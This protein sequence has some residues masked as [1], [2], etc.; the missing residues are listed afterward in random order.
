MQIPPEWAEEPAPLLAMLSRR[1]SGGGEVAASPGDDR[2]LSSSEP[3]L[4]LQGFTMSLADHFL[5]RSLGRGGGPVAHGV[6]VA[7]DTARPMPNPAMFKLGSSRTDGNPIHNMYEMGKQVAT[8]GPEMVWRIHEGHRKTDGKEVSIFVFEKKC[9]EKLHKPKRRETVTELL[10]ASV[11]Q[12]ERY[13]HPRI[14]Q[15]MHPVE[16]CPE[17]LAFASE[18]VLACLANVLSP[19]SEGDR[20][21]GHGFAKDYSFLDIELKY[22][23]LQITEALSF[24]HY[25]AHILHSNVCP[26]SIFVTKRGT[27]KLGGLEFSEKIGEQDGTESI[28]C[29]AW[30]S[31]IP[32]M[33]QPDLDFIA[34]EIQTT[35]QCTLLSDLFSLGMVIC[36]VFNNGKSLIEANHSNTTYMKQFEVLSDQLKNTLMKI[37]VALQEAVVR[38]LNRD[39]RQ[40]PTAQ[41]LSL[42]K[43]FS[44]PAVHAL[45]FLDVI[46]MKDPSQKT[47]FF[48]NT[49]PE[50]L[51][52]IPRKLWFQHV[53][54]CLR[55]EMLAQEVLAAVLQ[56][57]LYIISEISQEEYET[58]ILPRFRCIFCWPKSI[59]ASVTL[60]ENLHIILEKTPKDEIQSDVMPI[61]YSALESNTAQIQR[62]CLL[63]VPNVAEYIDE[64]A[65]RKLVFP[66]ARA[67]YEKNSIDLLVTLYML[68]ALERILD[69]LERRI[70]LDELLPLLWDVRLQDPDII[71]AAVNVYR[72][73]LTDNKKYGLS[74]NLMATRVMP[75]LLPLTMN[76]ALHLDQFT[77]LVEVLQEMLDTIDKNQRNKL[78]LDDLVLNSPDHRRLPALR[79]HIS[80]DNMAAVTSGA[81]TFHIPNLRVECRRKTNSA[82]DF[83]RKS[84]G[85]AGSSGP[86]SPDSNLLRVHSAMIGRRLSDNELLNPPK[87]R[88]GSYSCGS[89]T[90]DLRVGQ[91]PIRRHSSTCPSE[92]RA[93]VF[94][95]SPPM[96]QLERSAACRSRPSRN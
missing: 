17:T 30:S 72:V 53:W 47:N 31:R 64:E 39:P 21:N 85:S 74:V 20:S 70:I 51:P 96:V 55:E 6:A 88:V 4:S 48:R 36:A 71:Q 38:L 15:V 29:Q 79:H 42:I 54:P 93:S 68:L 18:P 80:S 12:L 41:L 14:L 81:P 13:R 50:V 87:I 9:A 44:D 28:H 19:A 16:E 56:P 33:A 46:N 8:A 65:A 3:A 35:S 66:R 94:S 73:M 76:A 58:I 2:C 40:R 1:S 34:P 90:S 52:Y 23:I 67:I 63:A 92:R 5:P 49:L 24:L 37:P 86:S 60:L 43:Y 59:Q 25:S 10:R 62:A 77:S 22:G 89:S 57:I 45:Q 83:S 7:R 84:S 26:S 78:K 61:L 91:L 69:K 32:K 27:W 11:K 82:E 95:L 75:S